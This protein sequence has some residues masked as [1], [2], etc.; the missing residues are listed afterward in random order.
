MS[1]TPIRTVTVIGSKVLARA[2][3]RVALLLDTRE[4]GHIALEVNLQSIG[5]LRAESAK[6]ETLLRQPGGKA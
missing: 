5:F 3:G 1:E 2:V 4:S 6:V